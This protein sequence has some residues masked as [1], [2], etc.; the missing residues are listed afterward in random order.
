MRTGTS[1]AMMSAWQFS[2]N[3]HFYSGPPDDFVADQKLAS[4]WIHGQKKT[5]GAIVGGAGT[6]HLGKAIVISPEGNAP[7]TGLMKAAVASRDDGIYYFGMLVMKDKS[8]QLLSIDFSAGQTARWSVM[9][10][11]ADIV[12]S[13]EKEGITPIT[14]SAPASAVIGYGL[15]TTVRWVGEQADLTICFD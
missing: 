2:K 1:D 3:G 13:I 15:G 14:L 5:E 7:L 4:V 10:R 9:R 11:G 12:I 6:D 8:I